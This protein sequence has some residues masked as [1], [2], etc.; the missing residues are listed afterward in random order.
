MQQAVGHAVGRWCEFAH[1]AHVLHTAGG[2]AHI[3]L[4]HAKAHGAVAG[5]GAGIHAFCTLAARPSKKSRT[6]CLAS[7]AAWV[8]AEIMDSVNKP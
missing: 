4:G 1:A 3:H 5:A 6:R 7:G 2:V 8:M